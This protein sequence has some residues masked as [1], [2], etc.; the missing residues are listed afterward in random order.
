MG[1]LY[2]WDEAKALIE[3]AKENGKTLVTT[4]G[5]FD[6]I[7]PGH[8]FLF[9]EAKKLGDLLFVGINADSS[10]KQ[11]KGPSRPINSERDRAFVLAGLEA[12]D[13]VCI[14]EEKTPEN[15]IAHIKPDIHVK[16]GDWKVDDVPEAKLVES[17]GGKFQSIPYQEG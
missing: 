5:C 15:W 13:G 16:G 3:T 17:W 9:T 6:I 4:N 2:T 10:V 1:K 14:F 11:N 12:V 8:V 7:H